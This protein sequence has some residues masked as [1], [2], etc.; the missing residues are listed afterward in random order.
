MRARALVPARTWTVL[1]YTR[2]VLPRISLGSVHASQLHISPRL[3][4]VCF[5][6][7]LRLHAGKN[8]LAV[9]Q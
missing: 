6:F 7:C 1:A 9:R 8:C 2:L 5:C 3:V 4:E